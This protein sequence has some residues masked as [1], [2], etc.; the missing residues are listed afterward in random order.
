M[1]LSQV[2]SSTPTFPAT[3]SPPY[4]G[5]PLSATQLRVDDLTPLQ[6]GVEAARLLL[7]GGG[8]RR[9]V[10]CTSN[11]SMVIQPLG[12]VLVTVTGTWTVVADTS[13]HSLNPTTL[14]G[15]LAANTRYWVYV[16]IV[17]GS[18]VFSASTTGPDSGLFYMTGDTSKLYVSTF[19]TDASANVLQY[20]QNDREYTY[21]S[22]TAVGGGTYGNLML[23]GGTSTSYSAEPYTAA[24]PT[25]ANTA[26]LGCRM[27][28][29][30]VGPK[31]GSVIPSDT[32]TSTSETLILQSYTA[33]FD[34]GRLTQPLTT[35]TFQYKVADAVNDTMYVWATGFTL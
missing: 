28:T 31:I 5:D 32:A 22:R 26:R 9:R 17:A 11:T 35:R 16:A 23:D 2:P 27:V 12:A 21:E 10:V 3:I 14:A 20:V 30:S 6:N 18:L 13:S 1:A 29:A 24:V 19:Y 15:S 4:D 8:I 34:M 33:Q 7:Y 25:Q